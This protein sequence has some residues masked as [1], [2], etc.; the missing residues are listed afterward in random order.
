MKITL[1]VLL[2]PEPF[3]AM[4][5]ILIMG[6]IYVIPIMVA[7]NKRQLGSIAALDLLLGWTL[8]GWVV[9]LCWALMDSPP[10]IQPTTPANPP[11]AKLCARCGRYSPNDAGFCSNCGDSFRAS[12]R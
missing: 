12:R 8:V 2:D 11:P 7:W 9:A 4:I 6:F 10:A 3:F 5:A 1:A